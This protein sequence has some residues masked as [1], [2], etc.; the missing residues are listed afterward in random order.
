MGWRSPTKSPR[1]HAT[2]RPV[3]IGT[4]SIDK[5]EHLSKL[6]DARGHRASGAQRQPHRRA[7]ADIVAHAG[8]AGHGHRLHQHGR[9]R[10]RH[11][12]GRRRRRAGRPARDLTE[13]HDSARID[14]QLIGRCGRQG[15]PGTFRQYLA[16]DDEPWRPDSAPKGTEYEAIGEASGGSYDHLIGLFRRA[17]RE[18]RAAPLPR[19]PRPD[20]LREAT[21]E[22]AAADGP[23]R[24]PRYAR[25]SSRRWK[26]AG[27]P[28]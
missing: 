13:M 27:C 10:H 15:D 7:E 28:Q 18:S 3:L 6:L 25:V 20:V 9:P 19:P 16:L 22:N 14:R 24:V 8:Q 26:H 2:G 5:S 23:G 12:A 11:Q 4:R 21:Q 1:L 17:Q